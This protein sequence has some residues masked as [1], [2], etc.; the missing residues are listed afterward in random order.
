M[1]HLTPAR[2]D[3][4]MDGSLSASEARRLAVHLADECPV[5]AEALERGPDLDVLARLLEAQAGVSEPLGAEERDRIWQGVTPPRR[6]SWLRGPGVVGVLLLAAALLLFLLPTGDELTGKGAD[7]V[8]TPE[9]VL[10]VVAARVGDQGLDLERR[11]SPGEVLSPDH[12][13]VFEVEVDEEAARY[14]WALPADQVHLLL[15]PPGSAAELEAPGA[16]RVETG[17][18]LEGERGEL[19]FVAAASVEVLDADEVLDSWRAGEPLAGVGYAV[20]T[21]EVAR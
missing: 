13:L 15:P 4:L 2:I 18:A 20:T 16:H 8:H 19:V 6:R 7:G 17:Y 14:L 9:V 21:V 5:C 10:R 11:V 3:A 1:I 12:T